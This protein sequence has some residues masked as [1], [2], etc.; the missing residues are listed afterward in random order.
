MYLIGTTFSFVSLGM[1]VYINAQGFATRGM[2]TVLL[3]A[4]A[5]IVLDPLFILLSAWACAARRLL[6]CSHR[7]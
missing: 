3:G 6:R 1:N 4:A 7:R 5:N 2:L